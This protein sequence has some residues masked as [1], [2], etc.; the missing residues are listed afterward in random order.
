MKTFFAIWV[1]F[2][3]VLLGLNYADQHNAVVEKNYSRCAETRE[4]YSKHVPPFAAAV[5]PIVALANDAPQ[6]VKFCEEQK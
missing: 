4:F 6:Y 2:Q 5:L 1:S 3:L